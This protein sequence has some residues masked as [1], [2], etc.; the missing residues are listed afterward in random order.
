[1]S[2]GKSQPSWRPTGRRVTRRLLAGGLALATVAGAYAGLVRGEKAAT[3]GARADEPLVIAHR[4]ASAYRPEHT[5]AAYRAAIGM[6]ADYIEPDVVSTK[7]GR[8]VARHDNWLADTTDVENHPEFAA[9]RTTKTVDGVA[10]TDWFTEDFTLAEL[11]TLRAEERIPGDRPRNTAFNG[12][13]LIPTLD[14]V[15]ALARQESVG[16]YPET[17]HPTYFDGLGLSME[18]PLLRDL[19]E[20]GFGRPGSRV[21]IQSFETANLRELARRTRL[22]LVQLID[23]TG[24]PWDFVVGGD[25]RT[26]DDLVTP[27]GL[28]WVSRYADG[29]GPAAA[30]VVPLNPD[31]TVGRPTT[32]VRDAHRLDMEVHPWTV[33][34]ENRFLPTNF[35]QGDRQSAEFVRATGDVTG[36]LAMLYR[37]G[38]DGVF[39][40]DPAIAVAARTEVL[41]G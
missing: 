10:R 37:L 18:E 36:W 32:L 39:C 9:R 16:V 7:D 17:K 25:P 20:N 15:L 31:G 19:D 5:L 28:R 34:P 23:A 40:D 4:G 29:I 1:M 38:V 6:G 13:D 8:L 3:A 33:R 35:Q 41:G 14:E 30:R 26:Y 12:T 11:R 27:E 2:H 21:F 22:P 24:K